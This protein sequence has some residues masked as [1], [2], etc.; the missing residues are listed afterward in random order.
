MCLS[1]FSFSFS[2]R[3]RGG[4]ERWE[5][6]RNH[7]RPL[8]NDEVCTKLIMLMIKLCAIMLDLLI[9]ELARL[10]QPNLCGRTISYT[11]GS[12]CWW[13][14]EKTHLNHQCGLSHKVNSKIVFIVA[15]LFSKMF[16]YPFPKF[17]KLHF[18]S[19]VKWSRRTYGILQ[20][21]HYMWYDSLF[22]LVRQN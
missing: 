21:K 11:C 17:T 10:T 1:P 3:K 14:M 9:M 13:N 2:E 12:W 16:I 8:P 19:N 5:R 15:Q 18:R 20:E 4:G 6:E 22:Y 7:C